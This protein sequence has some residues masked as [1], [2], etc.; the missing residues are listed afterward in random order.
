MTYLSGSD[1]EMLDK[2]IAQLKNRDFN[3]VS[4]VSHGYAWSHTA[5]NGIISVRDRLTEMGDTDEYIRYI[6]EHLCES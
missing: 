1:V 5:Q 4:E 6:E 2:Y 3:D